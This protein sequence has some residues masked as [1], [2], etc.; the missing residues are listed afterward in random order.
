MDIMRGSSKYLSLADVG[1][2]TVIPFTF[3]VHIYFLTEVL[4]LIPWVKR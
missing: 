4:T 1:I 3:I 2:F